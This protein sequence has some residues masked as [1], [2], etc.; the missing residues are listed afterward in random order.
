MTILY[1]SNA[2]YTIYISMFESELL[3]FWGCTNK[4][5]NFGFTVLHFRYW[6][7][8]Y[9]L[10]RAPTIVSRRRIGFGVGIFSWFADIGK[11]TKSTTVDS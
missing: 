6:K 4:N 2:R 11:T 10:N 1:R 8:L 5:R 3:E 9:V 7:D